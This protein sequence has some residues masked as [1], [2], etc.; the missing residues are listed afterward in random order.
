MAILF[1]YTG[2][3]GRNELNESTQN[4]SDNNKISFVDWCPTGIKT[5][6]YNIGDMKESVY[7]YGNNIAI[8]RFFEKR[9]IK[10]Y[11]S[12]FCNKA[13]I[14]WYIREH[15]EEEEF[16]EARENIGYI[17]KDYGDVLMESI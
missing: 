3:I 12:M 9:I 10:K 17:I 7:M 1:N 2:N 16:M 15:M 8:S 4:I 6:T 11:D 5:E 14:D 13:Y